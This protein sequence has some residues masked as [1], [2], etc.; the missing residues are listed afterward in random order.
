MAIGKGEMYM[1]LPNTD[2]GTRIRLMHV[3][4]TPET[5][6]SLVSIRCADEAGL[7]AVFEHGTCKLIKH[8]TRSELRH[9]SEHG[10]LYQ[11]VTARRSECA[12]P[13]SS[14]PSNAIQPTAAGNPYVPRP[15]YSPPLSGV[16]A[17]ELGAARGNT[18]VAGLLPSS[19]S[20]LNVVPTRSGLNILKSDCE[21]TNHL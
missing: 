4:H 5:V 18:P 11:V 2:G 13:A 9:M 17:S 14:R 3:L 10:G 15:D 6:F 8:S 16:D 1:L 12:F 7:T 21:R 19:F 20:M